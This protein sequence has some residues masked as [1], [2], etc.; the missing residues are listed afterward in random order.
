MKPHWMKPGFEFIFSL[1]LIV[2]MGLPPLVFAQNTKEMEIKI[3][4]GDTVVNGKNI[5]DLSAAERKDAMKDIDN[6]GSISGPLNGRREIFIRKRDGRDTGVQRMI[7]GSH[8]NGDINDDMALRFRSPKDSSVRLFKFHRRGVAGNDSSFTFNY[9][10]RNDPAVRFEGHGRDH[11]LMPRGRDMAFFNHRD[12]QTFDYNNTGSDGIST[13][14][15]FRVTDASPE[16]IKEMTGSAK[17]LTWRPSFRQAR[18]C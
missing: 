16:K 4:N 12:V 17:H 11:M 13:H 14:L 9:R 18:Y 2:I 7:I 6:L 10:M 15:S 1:S 3:T 8:M 5:K